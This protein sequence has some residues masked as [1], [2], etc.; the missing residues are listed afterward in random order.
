MLSAVASETL[1]IK[2]IY[3]RACFH[4]QRQA[5]ERAPLLGGSSAP[6]ANGQRPV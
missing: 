4:L 2:N 5:S 3:L 1:M 6:I